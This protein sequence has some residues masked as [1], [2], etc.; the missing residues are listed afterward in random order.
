[1]NVRIFVTLK[2]AVLDPQGKAIESSLRRLGYAGAKD[3]RVGKFIQM[4][5]ETKDLKSA[6]AQVEEM[7]Q[8]L[9]SNPVIE[10]ARYEFAE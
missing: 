2:A 7:C 10:D 6:K 5:L 1:V 3:V 8:K 9:L 4:K